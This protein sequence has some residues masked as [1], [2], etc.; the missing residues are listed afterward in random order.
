MKVEGERSFGAERDVVWDALNDP[1][2]MAALMPG[3]QSFDIKDDRNWT[4]KVKVPLGLGSLAMTIEFQQT[5]VREP[6]YSSLRA[7]GNGVGAILDM[8]TSFTL[9]PVQ[10][11]TKMSWAADVKILGPVGAMGQ[12]VLQPIVKQ[13]VEQV[14]TALEERVTAAS[15]DDGAE[16]PAAS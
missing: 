13:Q 11:G 7:K 3:V 5:E 6:E 10:E 14:L 16:P 8:E 4:A 2:K 15:D 9:E 12:R 1:S